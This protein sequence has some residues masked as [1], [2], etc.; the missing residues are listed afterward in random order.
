MAGEK[1]VLRVAAAT[2]Y[3][4]WLNGHFLGCGPARGPH[5]YFRVDQWDLGGKLQPGKNVIALEVAG[6]NA[7]SYYLLDQPS[8][9]QAEVVAGDRVLA[10]TAGEGE[11][12]AAQVL[13]YRVQKVQRYSFQRPF[14]EVYRLKPEW[15]RWRKDAA[16]PPGRNR[17]GRAGRQEPAAPAG[18]LPAIHTAPSAEDY[19]LRPRGTD[20]QAH[21]ALEGSLAGQ[22]QSE[23]EGLSGE[24]V[25][26]DSFDRGPMPAGCRQT[27]RPDQSYSCDSATAFG[28]GE[29]RNLD[30]GVNR[31]GFIGAK[32]T[33][34]KKTRLWFLFDE[35]LSKNDV[36]FKRLGC[37]N[38]VS[39]ELEP[40]SYQIESIEPY[41]FRYLKLLCLEGSCEVENVYLREFAHPPIRPNSRRAT[42]DSTGSSRRAW[43]RFGRTRWTSSW[44]APRGNGPVDSAT[45]FSLPA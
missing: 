17:D 39:Y 36:D 29:Y 31:T 42:I 41:T 4:A 32:V 27:A 21:A 38:I 15:D 13:D 20:R 37:V 8:F 35:I 3:R 18:A 1:V 34:P 26:H 22:H 5:G 30:M 7:N 43:R 16:A 2:I 14:T 25:G 9:L 45:A 6:Y 24:R 12:F 28:A 10:S 23:A 33:C 44:T 19:R 11:K 40:G